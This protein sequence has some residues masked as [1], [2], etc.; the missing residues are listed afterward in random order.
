MVI[1]CKPIWASAELYAWTLLF[2]VFSYGNSVQSIKGHFKGSLNIDLTL[3]THNEKKHV[4][5]IFSWKFLNL[6]MFKHD[7]RDH[8]PPIRYTHSCVFPRA[9]LVPPPLSFWK[10][11]IYDL[12]S[13][14]ASHFLSLS[15][16]LFVFATS[17]NQGIFVYFHFLKSTLSL[18]QNRTARIR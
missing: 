18:R 12:E 16:T 7:W 10:C 15:F 11:C 17:L 6:S 8:S 13:K 5:A 2:N 1:K 4:L 9:N 3:Y 14:I